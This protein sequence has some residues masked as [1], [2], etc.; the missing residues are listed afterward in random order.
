MTFDTD[1][2][3][4]GAVPNVPFQDAQEVPY[5]TPLSS[6]ELL[7]VLRSSAPLDADEIWAAF[8]SLVQ[9]VNSG[10]CFLVATEQA[11]RALHSPLDADLPL[12]IVRAVQTALVADPPPFNDVETH[13]AYSHVLPELEA[14]IQCLSSESIDRNKLAT[15]V[16]ALMEFVHLRYFSATLSV[17]KYVNEMLPQIV[18]HRAVPALPPGFQLN[19]TPLHRYTALGESLLAAL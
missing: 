1:A 4:T 7:A 9:Q 12:P 14:A 2:L 10:I 17:F 6:A 15:E 3:R 18:A 13:N 5:Y 19:G 11:V 16:E 8:T